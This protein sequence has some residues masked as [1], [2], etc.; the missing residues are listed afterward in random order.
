MKKYIISLGIFLAGAGLIFILMHGESD[1][2]TGELES[3]VCSE[4]IGGVS[5]LP[6]V[7]VWSCETKNIR[8]VVTPAGVVAC[9]KH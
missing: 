6:S 5:V 2:Q 3:F 1:A 7:R 4:F 9:F 8:C